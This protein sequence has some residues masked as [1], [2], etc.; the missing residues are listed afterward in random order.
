MTIYGYA[1]VSTGK[2]DTDAQRRA[3]EAAG[4]SEI[5]EEQ[6]SGRRARPAL[7]A[8]LGR[9]QAGDVVTVWKINRLGRSVPD[10]YR[11]A[12]QITA[13]GA[14]LRSLSESFDTSTTIGRAMLGM[15]AVFAQFE[16]EQT[17]EN[18]RGGLKAAK[19]RGKR[20]GRPP[21]VSPELA[22][23]I[24]AKLAGG[25]EVKDLAR[26]HRIDPATVRRIRQ[27]TT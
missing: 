12:E 2:Q 27:R 23:E 22:D 25:A 15:L 21:A 1:R 4:C 5:V 13:A 10:F 8:L 7:S 19:A 6:A 17:S 9:L 18:I 26:V 3:L 14:E 11:V 20:L 24:R 16:V